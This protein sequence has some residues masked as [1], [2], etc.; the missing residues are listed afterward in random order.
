[1]NSPLTNLLPEIADAIFALCEEHTYPEVAKMIRD[2]FG[3]TASASAL[4]RWYTTYKISD[5]EQTRAQYLASLKRGH[6]DFLNLSEDQIHLRLL[7]LA[8]R[9]ALSAAEIRAVT[10]SIC[11]F[12][13]YPLAE[14]RIKL[15]EQRQHRL[16]TRAQPL[17]QNPHE[18]F[19]P[20]TPLPPPLDD[21]A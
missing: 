1:M 12:R 20:T 17:Q 4:C 13:T 21:R 16:N 10:A 8:S 3:I 14:R 7:E 18:D 15:A 5:D 19:R 11:R 2:K 6:G 9:P